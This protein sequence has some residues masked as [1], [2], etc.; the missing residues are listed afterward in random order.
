MNRP[1]RTDGAHGRARPLIVLSICLAILAPTMAY[2]V[3]VDQGVF[4]YMADVLLKGGWPYVATWENDYPGLIFI[5]AV[6]MLVMGK[7]IAAFRLFDILVQVGSAYCILV[8]ARRA[9]GSMAAAIAPI[10]YCL[11]Y[12]SYGPWNTAQREGFG[13]FLVLAGFALTWTS[14]RRAPGVTAGLAGLLFGIAIT[15]KPTLLALSLFYLPLAGSFRTP[16]GRRTAMFAV[17]GLLLPTTIIV[18][19]YWAAGRLTEM[20]EACV[21]YHA[22]YTARLRGDASL[23]AYWWSKLTSLGRNA[24]VLPITFIPFIMWDP[25]RVRDRSMLFLAYVGATYAVFVQGTFAGYHYLPGLAI[26]AVLVGTMVESAT[27][28]LRTRWRALAAHPA[29]SIETGVIAAIMLPMA[30]VYMRNAPIERL[31]T[32][33]FLRPPV[34]DEFRNQ[35]VYDF[36]ETYEAAAYLKGHTAPDEPIQVWGYESFVY[37]LADR[38][39]SSRFQMTNP[40]VMHTPEGRLTPMQERWRDEFIDAVT[41]RPPAYI[42]VLRDDRWWW[43]PDEQSSEEL[44]DDFPAWKAIITSRYE[45]DHQIGRFLIYQR[46]R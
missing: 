1:P 25:D 20:Y 43:A 44:L 3:G 19:G 12:Q 6:Q 15:I 45:L 38:P 22:V 24:V 31:V 35:N 8:V 4:F 13:L 28:W 40:L 29:R 21:A 42:A 33:A 9:S 34:V 30:A 16:G 2:R 46:R 37:F 7:S 39:A 5:Q 11:I 36:T 27:G 26:G 18:G 32:L 23:I 17:A 41:A 14:G 10:L